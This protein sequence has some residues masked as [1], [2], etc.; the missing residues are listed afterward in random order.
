MARF[1]EY[2]EDPGAGG[3][4]PT[5]AGDDQTPGRCG[6]GAT[7]NQSSTAAWVTGHAFDVDGGQVVRA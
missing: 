5:G 6:G 4:D 2:L 7:V 3:A 1:E